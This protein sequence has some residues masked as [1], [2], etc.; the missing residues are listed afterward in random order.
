[1]ITLSEAQKLTK[2]F[3]DKDGMVTIEFSIHKD[4]LNDAFKILNQCKTSIG[5]WIA[6]ECATC[7]G[8]HGEGNIHVSLE[9]LSSIKKMENSSNFL[10][11]QN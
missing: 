10:Q 9:P 3:E 11:K 7:V 8:Y 2:E 1:M 6:M 4:D 5:K